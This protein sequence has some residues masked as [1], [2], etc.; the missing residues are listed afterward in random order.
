MSRH[1]KEPYTDEAA[2]A[3]E[4]RDHEGARVTGDHNTRWIFYVHVCDFTF[5]FF[6]PE[7]IQQYIDFY[8]CKTLPSSRTHSEFSSGP[9]ASVGEGQSKFE[10]LPAHLRRPNKRLQVIKALEK[11]AAAFEND[12]DP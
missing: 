12:Q 4:I 8:R 3:A 6:S 1:W 10:R 2:R 5:T 11:A 7:M 9:A